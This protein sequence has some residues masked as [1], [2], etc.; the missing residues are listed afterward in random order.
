VFIS[1]YFWH[2]VPKIYIK[3]VSALL[4][5]LVLE[6]P[7][8]IIEQKIQKRRKCLSGWQL[9]RVEWKAKVNVLRITNIIKKLRKRVGW[10]ILG[11]LVFYLLGGALSA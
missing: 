11:T 2:N 4:L 9:E 1:D 8:F 5:K 10:I 6:K 7:V 3:S